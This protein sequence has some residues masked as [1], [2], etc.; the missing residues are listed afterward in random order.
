M[1]NYTK[2]AI[3]I[4]V[5]DLKRIY[6]VFNILL[7]SLYIGYLVYAITSP[8]GNRIIN[9]VLLALSC[10]YLAFFVI[11]HGRSDTSAKRIKK[12]TRRVYAW[13]KIAINTFTVAIASYGI[14]TT[15]DNV[16]PA[17]VV[18][19]VLMV[20]GWLM[21]VMLQAAIYFIDSR[22]H[23]VIEAIKAD[24]EAT[25]KPIT[26]V[27]TAVKK[28]VGKETPKKEPNRLRQFLD[29]RVEKKKAKKKHTK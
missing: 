8:I 6:F 26:S 12:N 25:L 23:L 18:M 28:L 10:I 3:D 17:A 14:Y 20:L 16:K 2:T 19:L 4:I 7:L 22:A 21:S 1:F 24:K 29:E 9:G 13:T 15:V 11:T 5:N 27:T